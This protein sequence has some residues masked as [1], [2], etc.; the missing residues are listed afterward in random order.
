MVPSKPY[1]PDKLLYRDE[2]YFQQEE[3][4][5]RDKEEKEGKMTAPLEEQAD[6]GPLVP[7]KVTIYSTNKGE[8]PAV[9]FSSSVINM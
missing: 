9:S 1:L 5:E 4:K 8:P 2:N 7:C 3:D 6:S